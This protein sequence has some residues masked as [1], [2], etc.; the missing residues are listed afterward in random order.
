LTIPV[1]S[2]SFLSKQFDAFGKRS[3][4]RRFWRCMRDRG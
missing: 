2:T 3:A 4:N 1:H